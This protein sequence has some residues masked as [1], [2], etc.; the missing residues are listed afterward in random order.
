MKGSIRQ[1]DSRDLK[2]INGII[3]SAVMA[4]PLPERVKRLSLPVLKYDSIDMENLR[5]LVFERDGA[6]GG[7]HGDECGR[8][9]AGVAAWGE[10]APAG[11]QALLHGLFVDPDLQGEGIGRALQQAVFTQAEELGMR[12]VVLR[13][14]R[15]SIGYFESCGYEAVPPSPEAGNA[16]PYRYRKPLSADRTALDGKDMRRTRP[17]AKT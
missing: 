17:D 8:V 1:A 10:E 14:E 5:M 9:I 15:V 11:E 12:A 3:E 13:A 2:A 6:P 4:W 16:Y 7:E